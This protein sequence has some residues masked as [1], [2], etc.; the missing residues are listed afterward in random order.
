MRS[1]V[2]LVLVA[3]VISGCF[4][5]RLTPPATTLKTLRTIAIVPVEA[6]PLLLHPQTRADRDAI[7]P[8]RQNSSDILPLPGTASYPGR[9]DNIS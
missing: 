4:A 6:S 3:T 9:T 8:S 1:A 7:L 2:A 5:A